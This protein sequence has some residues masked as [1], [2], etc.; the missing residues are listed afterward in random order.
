[1]RLA[2]SRRPLKRDSLGGAWALESMP[3]P[4]E[5]LERIGEERLAA[6]LQADRDRRRLWLRTGIL[7]VIWPL[8][9][10]SLVAWSIHT[11][12]AFYAEIAFWAGLG[13]GDG[14]TLFTLVSAWRTAEGRGWV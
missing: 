12:D 14:A 9:G 4:R 6:Q 3:L 5:V 1:V 2:G 10:L 13:I 11:T 8:L 7:C